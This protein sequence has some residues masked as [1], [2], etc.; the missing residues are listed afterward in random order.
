VQQFISYTPGHA[1]SAISYKEQQ[2]PTVLAKDEYFL[3]SSTT[4]YTFSFHT[5]FGITTLRLH[6]TYWGSGRTETGSWR[7]VGTFLTG[8]TKVKIGM[9]VAHKQDERTHS[10]SSK[11][12]IVMQHT[13][14][15][16]VLLILFCSEKTYSI[17]Q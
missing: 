6:G 17:L 15:V 9:S 14:S 11:G 8:K 16:C 12:T 1:S 4:P 3:P 10:R 13:S 7:E 5:L 2:S